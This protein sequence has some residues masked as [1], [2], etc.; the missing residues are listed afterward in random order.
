LRDV[1]SAAGRSSEGESKDR[2]WLA[3]RRT[4]LVS[5]LFAS[6]SMLDLG[7]SGKF[8]SSGEGEATRFRHRALGYEI[9]YPAVLAEPGWVIAKL[10]QSDLLV[11]HDDGA[12]WTI[13]SNCRATSARVETLAAELGRATEGNELG[14]GEAISHAGLAGWTQNFERN[15]GGRRIRIKTVTLRGARCTYDWIL[16]APS[17][18]R[19][20]ELEPRF[21]QWWQSFEPGPQELQRRTEFDS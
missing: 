21:D 20:E 19:F 6:V 7:C 3:A 2:R 16:L 15:E 1:L 14:P 4:T 9:A 17:L 18:E 10:D 12:A 5:F 8:L 13:A 11:R